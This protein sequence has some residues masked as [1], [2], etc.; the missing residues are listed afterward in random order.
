MRSG[1]SGS[2]ASSS[3]RRVKRAIGASAVRA[4]AAPSAAPRATPRGAHDQQHE[5]DLVELAVDLVERP[6]HLHRARRA[7]RALVST[8]RCSAVDV[9]VGEVLA[10]AA[11]GDLAGALARPAAPRS[12]PRLARAR[13]RRAARPGRSPRRRRSARAASRPPGGPPGPPNRARPASVAGPASAEAI[14]L[15]LALACERVVHLAAQLG[16]HA[17]VDGE[18]G[19]HHRQRHGQRRPRPRCACAASWLAQRRSPRRAP[20]GAA[21]A[22]PRRRACGAGSRCTRAARSRRARSRSPTRARRS[23]LCGSTR[24]GLSI[25]SSSSWYSVRVSSTKPSPT[26]HAVARR[27]EPEL[28]EAQLVGSPSLGA[29]APQQR[30]QPRLQLAHV[31]GL[32]EVVVGARVEAVDAVV[33]RVA[34][35]EHQDR[36]RGCPP[37]AAGG[38]P[39]A[40][41]C[42]GRP[43]SSTTASGAAEATC[44]ERLLR[45]PAADT[46]S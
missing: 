38:R 18:R 23:R 12:R 16:A 14:E 27:V 9:G 30:P 13:D 21:D 35:G 15:E 17:H 1:G 11:A 26:A 33:D 37:R 5:Q 24:R 44:A 3:V 31:E 36:G 32:H 19:H 34:R 4:T 25:S 43:T 45:R 2:A 10:L 46:V 22:R 28:L 40:R 42:P 41:R 20:C 6:R 8:R 39:R 29:A 7:G